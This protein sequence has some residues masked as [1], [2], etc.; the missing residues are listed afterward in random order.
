M[1]IGAAYSMSQ[2]GDRVGFGAVGDH[3]GQAGAA[4]GSEGLV[5]DLHL[6]G[7]VGVLPNPHRPFGAPFCTS[8]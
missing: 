2:P 8:V 4:I 1:S 3:A 6:L 5:V 7:V